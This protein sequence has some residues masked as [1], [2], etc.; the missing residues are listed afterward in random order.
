MLDLKLEEVYAKLQINYE[1][2]FTTL[3]SITSLNFSK[4]ITSEWKYVCLGFYIIKTLFPLID[5]SEKL[6]LSVQETKDFKKFLKTMIYIGISTKLQP[7]L[8]FYSKTK[9]PE[10][11]DIFWNYNVLKCVTFGLTE[12]LKIPVLRISII[13][14]AF[15]DILVALYQISYCPLKKPVTAIGNSDTSEIV[16]EE[17]YEKLLQEQQCFI[18]ILNHLEKTVHPNIFVKNTMMIMHKNSPTWFRKHVSQT[19]TNFLRS[20]NGVELV[21]VALFSD[22]ENDTAHIWKI[23]EIFSKLILSCKKF[24]DFKENICKQLIKLLNKQQEEKS[25]AEIIFPYCTKA[26]YKEDQELCK[27]IFIREIISPLLYFTYNTHKFT[28][29]DITAKLNLTIRMLHAV[30]VQNAAEENVVPVDILQPVIYVIFRFYAST[31]ESSFEALNNDLKDIL[32]H[33]LEHQSNNYINIFDRFLFDLDCKEILS[34]RNDIVI[35][36]DAENIK[37][38]KSEHS[39]NYSSA[40]SFEYLFKLI[41][42]KPNLLVNLFSYLL[43]CITNEN[44]YFRKDN[45]DLLDVED[46]L[47]NEY[48]ARKISVYKLLSELA[49]EKCVQNQLNENP[50]DI[51]QYVCKVLNKTIELGTHLLED[52]DS[53]GYQ[54]VF[55]ILII[56]ENLLSNSSTH[57]P[58]KFNTLLEPLVKI[59]SET[60]NKEMKDIIKSILNTLEGTVK[61]RSKPI[62]KE[63]KTELDKAIDDICDALIPTRGHGLLTLTKLIAKR[64]KNTIERK[65]FVLNILQVIFNLKRFNIN[66]KYF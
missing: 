59:Q 44:K 9:F 31:Q 41:K 2:T 26:F 6:F 3:T 38:C 30:F 40:A 18:K 34:F 49:E 15:K 16:T 12:L 37:L 11:R 55:T 43:N 50:T 66:T 29:E 58:K 22:H 23:L 36:V 5:K 27:S 48:F 8:P 14:E 10:N 52:S 63:S 28:D 42:L 46:Y 47:S 32:I 7:N 35:Q 45:D 65:Q 60:K 56:L 53:D 4:N 39:V 25:F 20:E 54:S 17:I 21:A 57:D 33:Y 19:L 64:D 51:V 1:Q 13:P 24:P 62:D 61:S